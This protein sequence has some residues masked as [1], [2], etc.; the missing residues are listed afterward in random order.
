MDTKDNTR[1]VLKSPEGMYDISALIGIVQQYMVSRI[2]RAKDDMI[3]ASG[4]V[5]RLSQIAGKYVGKDDPIMII[6]GQHGLPA[7]GELLVPF[8][9]TYP[10]EGWMRGSHWGARD[11]LKERFTPG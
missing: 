5:A 7:I 8:M 10:V 9:H 4:S 6:R 1:V 2:W 3:C 11:K